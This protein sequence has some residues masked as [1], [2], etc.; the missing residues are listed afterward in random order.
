MILVSEPPDL[1]MD[2]IGKM[3]ILNSYFDVLSSRYSMLGEDDNTWD[4]RI[5]NALVED[6]GLYQC[7]ILASSRSGPLRSDYVSVT[8]LAKPQP[9]I[10]TS[11][12]RL[13][14]KEGSNSLVQCISK[15]SRPETLITWRRNGHIL[16]EGVENRVTTL[17]DLKTM[18]V[19][20]LTFSVNS[21]MSDDIL[22]C[23]ATN[24]AVGSVETID[25]KVIVESKPNIRIELEN[26]GPIYEGDRVTFTCMSD[27]QPLVT[28]YSWSLGGKH[29]KD[30][31]GSSIL[32][33]DV[34]RQMHQSI[35]ICSARNSAGVNK[36]YYKLNI[37]CRI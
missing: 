27:T 19:S 8:V 14:V 18:T 10:I 28:D 36:A 34:T 13:V 21:D 25:T 3:P 9:P 12:P 26:E 20:T 17:S 24:H 15:G 29:V 1:C 37:N 35:I 23:E 11:G 5:R 32:T 2:M 31:S 33:V 4:L 16:S 22:T 6:E 7:Q 30:S